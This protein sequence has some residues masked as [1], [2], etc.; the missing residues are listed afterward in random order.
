MSF[1]MVNW[2]YEQDLPPS[3]KFLLVTIADRADYAD[4]V[5]CSVCGRDRDYQY[6]LRG[7]ISHVRWFYWNDFWNSGHFLRPSLVNIFLILKISEE[8]K[9]TMTTKSNLR[10]DEKLNTGE[11]IFGI[12]I[13]LIVLFIVFVVIFG[14]WNAWNDLSSEWPYTRQAK[15]KTTRTIDI[16]SL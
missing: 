9:I 14:L 15:Q 3:P 2:A 4:A 12:F 1:R 13:I 5:D 10:D 7:S 11:K 8:R 16:L 6:C